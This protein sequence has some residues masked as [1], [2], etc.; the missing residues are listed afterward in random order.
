MRGTVEGPDIDDY[1]GRLLAYVNDELTLKADQDYVDSSGY[2]T[3]SYVARLEERLKE[4]EVSNVGS[5]QDYVD[6][7]CY[8]SYVARLEERH[9]DVFEERIKGLVLEQRLRTDLLAIKDPEFRR[10]KFD[11][12]Q[13]RATESKVVLLALAGLLPATVTNIFERLSKDLQD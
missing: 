2:A 8:E 5:D 10:K 13:Q 11:K 4:L 7:T 1:A 12:Y 6:S 3:T 9:K